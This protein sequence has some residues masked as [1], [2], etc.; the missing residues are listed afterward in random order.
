ML[1]VQGGDTSRKCTAPAAIP[2]PSDCQNVGS[3]TPAIIVDKM[4]PGAFC[5]GSSSASSVDADLG[6]V[7]VNR[8]CD[9]RVSCDL[10]NVDSLC[11]QDITQV[12]ASPS[13]SPHISNCPA[14][15]VPSTVISS[16]VQPTSTVV[17]SSSLL[18]TKTA[19]SIAT[20]VAPTT[21]LSSA[22]PPSPTTC[23]S[24]NPIISPGTECDV[25]TAPVK[26]SGPQIAQ[27]AYVVTPSGVT[28]N[29]VFTNC[30]VGT[31]CKVSNGVASCDWDDSTCPPANPVPPV[32][33][34]TTVRPPIIS[35]VAQPPVTT[36][37]TSFQQPVTTPSIPPAP[38]QP[39]TTTTRP[40]PVPTIPSNS[41]PC[42]VGFSLNTC[43]ENGVAVCVYAATQTGY[44]YSGRYVVAACPSGLVC[45]MGLGYPVCDVPGRSPTIDSNNPTCDRPIVPVPP[46]FGTTAIGSTP[47]PQ[48]NSAIEISAPTFVAPI[49]TTTST[50]FVMPVVMVPTGSSNENVEPGAEP[51][52]I[53]ENPTLPTD[54]EPTS[55]IQEDYETPKPSCAKTTETTSG[56]EIASATLS[57]E[58]ITSAEEMTISR[59]T[60]DTSTTVTQSSTTVF[61]DVSTTLETKGVTTMTTE[62]ATEEFSSTTESEEITTTTELTTT[63][64]LITITE[65]VTTVVEFTTTTTDAEPTTSEGAPVSDVTPE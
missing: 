18:P 38:T 1:D 45:S 13:V 50:V 23:Q 48:T 49:R 64:E 16:T 39:T 15:T 25:P 46:V 27:C 5:F 55:I 20:S 30:A 33:S 29:Y 11:K 9:A 65:E 44:G 60:Y 19:I 10:A 4:Q 47:P 62:V 58:T 26:C 57:S 43:V 36:T 63:E 22:A 7:P 8:N 14:A 24:V 35:S 2:T 28:G 32:V 59:S 61:E 17:I 40:P 37:T 6:E 51:S 52:D 31:T 53:V 3:F 42:V 41:A 54:A 34:A 12:I 21:A 56:S